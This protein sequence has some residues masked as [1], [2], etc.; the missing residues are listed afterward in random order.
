[1]NGSKMK[2]MRRK[3]KLSSPNFQ[4]SSDTGTHRNGIII[5]FFP[6]HTKITANLEDFNSKGRKPG[7][8]WMAAHAILTSFSRVNGSSLQILFSLVCTFGCLSQKLCHKIVYWLNV[9]VWKE[10]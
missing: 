3:R 2:N 1:M 7:N 5:A 8:Q 10:P 4:L 9:K 6:R